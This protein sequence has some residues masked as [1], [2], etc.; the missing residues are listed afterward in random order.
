MAAALA[1]VADAVLYRPLPVPD[2]ARVF[3]VFTA[4]AAQPLG[5]FSYPDFDD[6]R[7]SLRSAQVIAQSEVLVAVAR[8][9]GD[10]AL[11]RMGLAVTPDYFDVLRVRA[12]LGRTFERGDSRGAVVVLADAFW[13]ARWGGDARVIGR[14]IELSAMPF[15]V[16]GVAPAGFGLDRFAHEDFYVP[17]GAYEAGLLPSVGRPLED[18]ARRFLSVYA[19]LNSGATLAQARAEIAAIGGRVAETWRFT[20][21]SEIDARRYRDRMMPVVAALLGMA[22]GLIL[23]VASVNVAGLLMAHA[24]TKA[25][26][27]AIQFALGATRGRLRMDQLAASGSVLIAALAIGAPL[28]WAATAVF[29]KM[30]VLPSDLRVEIAAQPGMR[31]MALTAVAAALSTCA[32]AL[33]PARLREAWVVAEIALATALAAGAWSL[34]GAIHATERADP[35]FRVDRVL[36]LALDP[37]QVRYGE[38]RGRAFYDR[39]LDR[40]KSLPGVRGAALGQSA[41]LGFMGAQR[42]IGI[43]G[44]AERAT[45]WMNIVTPEYF[46]VLRIPILRGRG[47]DARDGAVAIVNEELEKRCPVGSRFRMNGREVEVIGVARNA[48]YFSMGERVLP[49]FYLPFA[50]NYASRMV[51]HVETESDLARAIVEEIRAIDPVQPVSEIRPLKDYVTQGATFQTRVALDAV[52]P[53][54]VCALMLALAGL[55]G[56]VSRR[57]IARRR[58]IGIRMAIGAR[59]WRVAAM[60]LGYGAKLAAIGIPVGMVL[61]AAGERWLS[62]LIS[63]GGGN[64]ALSAGVV[65]ALTLAAA[66]A[67]ARKAAR[68]DPARCL[69]EES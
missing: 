58:E 49:F 56:V 59:P 39:V 52:G 15:T 33:A 24:E 53:V 48:K 30:A 32:C 63:G 69:R 68:M 16:I 14:R 36:T 11:V 26:D 27:R 3:P 60:M 7:R 47:F 4:S 19:R 62:R 29:Q 9:H 28:A 55:H 41:P 57:A 17:V 42:S 10:A 25:A 23:L 50:R 2:A 22:G 20:A 46:S 61:A 44:E 65:L 66:M 54:A 43:P 5:F 34:V 67:P 35:G 12:E 38:A 64:V 1:S 13:R 51:L 40:V 18:R 6:L 21:M 31:S 37:G 45:I 8:E